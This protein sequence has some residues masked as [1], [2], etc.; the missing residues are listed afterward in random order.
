MKLIIR[1]AVIA[2]LTLIGVS[3][4]AGLSALLLVTILV[5]ACVTVA[6]FTTQMITMPVDRPPGPAWLYQRNA[7]EERELQAAAAAWLGDPTNP[8]DEPNIKAFEAD[9][10]RILAGERL[11]PP[12]VT[13]R[14]IGGHDAVEPGHPAHPRTWRPLREA[15]R[16]RQNAPP[17]LRP[18]RKYNDPTRSQQLLAAAT[19]VD[20]Y[21]RYGHQLD[22]RDLQRDWKMVEQTANAPMSVY[23]PVG[24]RARCREVH[25][26][27][28][29]KAVKQHHDQSK[30][31]VLA[32]NVAMPAD[33]NPITTG[34]HTPPA[35]MNEAEFPPL[36]PL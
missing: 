26:R 20:L 2:L 4:V 36:R 35:W 11:R 27:Y 22:G 24:V 9:A 7:E 16:E 30:A 18:P 1:Y 3:L 29:G 19:H 21:A 15:Q 34:L 6:A 28:L 8:D 33:V 12:P 14:A 25:D 5:L 13:R 17:P 31:G 32:T 10:A 23:V